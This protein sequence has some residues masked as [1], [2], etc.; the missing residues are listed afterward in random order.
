[1][2]LQLKIIELLG[3]KNYTI[4]Q[5]AKSLKE[6]YSFVNR[7]VNKMIED[8]L[9]LKE[10]VGHSIVCQLHKKS[11]KTKALTYLIEVNRRDD[12]FKK[13]KELKLIL[14][15][16]KVEADAIGI[17]GSYAKGINNKESDID[18]FIISN[19]KID[20]TSTIRTIHAKYGKEISPLILSREQFKTDKPIIKEII[21]YHILLTGFDYFINHET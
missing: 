9:I 4:N 19:K 15:E 8:N 20:M 7:T 13:N 11:D 3:E 2:R 1:M 5:I 14:E 10:V 12:F 21:K 17:F 18:I 16:I 6:S